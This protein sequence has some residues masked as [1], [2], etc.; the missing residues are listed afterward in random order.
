VENVA[1]AL[2]TLRTSKFSL[3]EEGGGRRESEEKWVRRV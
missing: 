2:F 3:G 1:L